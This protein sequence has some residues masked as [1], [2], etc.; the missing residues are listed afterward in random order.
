MKL[1]M[2]YNRRPKYGSVR[3]LH[4]PRAHH[5]S[6]HSTIVL[7]VTRIKLLPKILLKQIGPVNLSRLCRCHCYSYRLIHYYNFH[8]LDVAPM[9][10]LTVIVLQLI[11]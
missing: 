8:Y 7:S 6:W 5:L 1:I 10:V 4:W 11:E 9:A 3:A 2:K